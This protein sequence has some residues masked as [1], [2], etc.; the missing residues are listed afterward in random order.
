[1]KGNVCMGDLYSGKQ[2]TKAGQYLSENDYEDP[3]KFNH[4]FEVLVY[5]RTEHST[6]LEH[7]FS[8]LQDVVHPI[9][10]NALFAKRLK[11]YVSI[12]SKLRRFENMT[13]R[14][15]QDIGGCRAVVSSEK[16]VRKIIR[17]LRRKQVFH[18]KDRNFRY[19][20]YIDKPKPDGYRS[21]HIVGQFQSEDKSLKNIELQIRTYLQH[22]WATALE[23][24][25]LFTNQSLKTNQGKR[26][27]EDFF[28]LV[29]SLFSILDN[30]PSYHNMEVKNRVDGFLVK[31]GQAVDG[32]SQQLESLNKIVK[33]LDIVVL[34]SSFANS[35]KIIGDE[36]KDHDE[37]GYV[38]LVID[39]DNGQLEYTIFDTK[40]SSLAQEKYAQEENVAASPDNNLIVALVFSSSVEDVKAAYPNFFADSSKFI[41]H[42]DTLLIA[43]KIIQKSV[44][45]RISS[46]FF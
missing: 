10:K 35:L 41:E 42:L 24:I 40:D 28:R 1:M 14:K 36:I 17:E 37:A 43:E 44:L 46:G 38:L 15:M 22:Y 32:V 13:L 5:W 39:P 20:D 29:A 16:K 18:Y 3:E 34:F 33:Q 6:A 45:K 27:W 8:L 7:A 25:D 2:V 9:E 30:I 21:Y 23:I 31:A 11:R 12:V 19:K 4:C 26:E